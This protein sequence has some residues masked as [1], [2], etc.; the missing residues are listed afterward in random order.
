MKKDVIKN[1]PANKLKGL[2]I[3]DEIYQKENPDKKKLRL[4]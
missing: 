1:S 4:S 2:E 3:F